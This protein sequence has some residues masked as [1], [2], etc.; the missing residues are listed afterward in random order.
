MFH[1][2]LLC[3]IEYN[4]NIKPSSKYGNRTS[5]FRYDISPTAKGVG[6]GNPTVVISAGKMCR[7]YRVRALVS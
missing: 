7:L 3:R 6:V 4:I 2:T 5:S 1:S